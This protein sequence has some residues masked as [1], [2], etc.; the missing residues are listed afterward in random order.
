MARVAGHRRRPDAPTPRPTVLPAAPAATPTPVAG[1]TGAAARPDEPDLLVVGRIGKPQGI[2]GEPAPPPM[3]VAEPKAD[4]REAFQAAARQSVEESGAATT[5]KKKAAPKT[6]ASDD[7]A[8]A[9]HAAPPADE[10]TTA[11]SAPAEQAPAEQPAG[12]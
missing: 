8:P 12:E 2:K 11:E 1:G 3:K 5:P 4:K 7:Q 9:G 6:K 10:A